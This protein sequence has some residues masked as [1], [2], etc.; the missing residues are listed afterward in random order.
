MG[1]RIELPLRISTDLEENIRAISAAT[2]TS[3]DVVV[4]R[5]DLGNG[6]KAA[7]FFIDGLVNKDILGRDFLGPL[8]AAVK[9]GYWTA[10]EL[11]SSVIHTSEVDMVEE[12]S[13]VVES[14]LQGLV[15]LFI[16]GSSTALTVEVI[17]WPQRSVGEPETDV[18]IRG[19][20]EGF[21]E[22]VRMNVA[23]LRRKIHHPDFTVE[24]VR[25]GRYTQTDVCLVYVSSIVNQG[26]LELAR[27]R[28]SEID[29]DGVM[30]TGVIE[31]L[32]Q[33]TPFSLFPTM[34]VAE[35]PDIAASRLL[36]G[37]IA[38]LADGSPIA[39][40][41]PMLFVEGLQ[42]SEDYYTR[43][44]Y[45]SWLRIIRFIAFVVNLY[46]PGFFLAAVGFHQQIIPFKLLLSMS[47]AESVTPFS[48]GASMLLI[49]LVYEILR[50]AGVRLPRPAGQAIS[51][52]GAIVM[53]DA[54]VNANLISAPVLIVLAIT[55]VASFVNSAYT[56]ASS[57]LRLL[58]LGLGWLMGLFGLLLG[59]LVLVVYLCSL[60]SFCTPFFAPF[61]PFLPRQTGDTIIRSPLWMLRFRPSILSRNRRRMADMAPDK[62]EKS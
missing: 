34:G 51:I 49:W 10:G 18:V 37:R 7:V 23:L 43:F 8:M 38:I 33:D 45:A 15:G 4:R 60:E 41:I 22:G 13:T 36:E 9:D 30:D 28:L 42:N 40:T 56:D 5:F 27:Q 20:R 48:T 44:Y 1:S 26:A 55:I 61:G 62:G 59:S 12:F 39:L 53:G 14:V 24:T 35:K 57:I 47:A 17:S 58:F 32:V 16:D 2:A 31:Q 54:A 50:E 6:Q 21:I 19:P 29:I 11:A 46:L 25:L 3:M 52:V